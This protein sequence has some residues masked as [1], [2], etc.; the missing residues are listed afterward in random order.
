MHYFHNL[1]M[2]SRCANIAIPL[3]AAIMFKCK[4]KNSVTQAKSSPNR[5]PDFDFE[6]YKKSKDGLQVLIEKIC[7]L[8][9]N[10][11]F[12]G[13]ETKTTA[14]S[15]VIYFAP[16]E[17]TQISKRLTGTSVTILWTKTTVWKFGIESDTMVRYPQDRPL[18]GRTNTSF[19]QTEYRLYS[20]IENIYWQDFL[21]VQLNCDYRKEW[22]GWVQLLEP[23]Q[24][25]KFSVFYAFVLIF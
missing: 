11:V 20:N 12:R 8:E 3:S 2:M 18:P 21:E 13:N 25:L 14:L 19:M 15:M 4:A 17:S 9:K 1:E 22:D 5:L 23:L 16:V 24:W 6:K 10:L 7:S